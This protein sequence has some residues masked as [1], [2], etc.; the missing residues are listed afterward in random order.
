LPVH[1]NGMRY[2]VY[3]KNKN[4]IASR[5][6][7]SIGGGFIID[8]EQAKLAKTPY[9]HPVPFPFSTTKELLVHCEQ[10]NLSIK[11]VMMENE[12]FYRSEEEIRARLLKIAIIMKECIEKGCASS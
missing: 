8:E 12:K 1:T 3:D 2:S 4:E 9:D 7:Y 6:F 11:E 5:V 10:N